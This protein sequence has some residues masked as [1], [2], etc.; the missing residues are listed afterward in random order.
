MVDQKEVI[1]EAEKA[2]I[3]LNAVPSS[4]GSDV[5]TRVHI[6]WQFTVTA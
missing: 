1:T 2:L 6:L 4:V 3:V 5:T